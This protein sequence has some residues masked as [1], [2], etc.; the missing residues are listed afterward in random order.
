MRTCTR[1]TAFAESVAALSQRRG[2]S[3][4]LACTKKPRWIAPAGLCILAR[5]VRVLASGRL[6]SV[7]SF[8]H[9]AGPPIQAAAWLGF[10]LGAAFRA[11]TA[12]VMTFTDSATMNRGRRMTKLLQHIEEMRIRLSE[13]ASGERVLVQALGDALNRLD[14]Q[15]LRGVR[16]IAT[17]HWL[18]REEILGELW[19]LAGGIGMV[20]QP[21]VAP[22]APDELPPQ[23]RGN[24]FQ[25]R[26]IGPRDWRQALSNRPSF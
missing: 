21:P 12:G 7:A 16:M 23:R 24:G 15:L 26:V 19:D 5:G 22:Q 10:W 20:R 1:P 9:S 25:E 6:L 17:E 13:I 2:F 8:C 11:Q 18:R 3:E 4:S 14:Q